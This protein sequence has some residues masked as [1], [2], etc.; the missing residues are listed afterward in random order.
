MKRHFLPFLLLVSISSCIP[1]GDVHREEGK[2]FHASIPSSGAVGG[3][4][5]ALYNDDTYQVCSIGGIGQKCYE[6][7]YTL[8]QDTLVLMNLSKE[9]HL[10]SN[11]LLISRYPAEQ[12]GS[13]GEVTQLDLSNH[14]IVGTNETHFVI[15]MDS[16][17]KLR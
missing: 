12:N 1:S 14:K 8:H 7:Q 6:G 4:Y 3:L 10:K 11:R 13:L 5:F 2:I 17:T 9:I 15:R 16:L